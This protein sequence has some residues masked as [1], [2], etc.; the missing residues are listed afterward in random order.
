MIGSSGLE[1]FWIVVGDWESEPLVLRAI[2]VLEG[3][4]WELEYAGEASWIE[5]FRAWAFCSFLFL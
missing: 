5:S 4:D 1:V 3:D 2:E